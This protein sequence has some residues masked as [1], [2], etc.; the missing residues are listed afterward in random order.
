MYACIGACVYVCICIWVCLCICIHIHLYT[1]VC[2][3][4]YALVQAHFVYLYCSIS[5]IHARVSQVFLNTCMRGCVGIGSGVFSGLFVV[6]ACCWCGRLCFGRGRDRG[7]V[8][9]ISLFLRVLGWWVCVCLYTRVHTHNLLGYFK[10]AQVWDEHLESQKNSDRLKRGTH[11]DRI[12]VQNTFVYK[13]A[14]LQVLMIWANCFFS[15]NKS[16]FWEK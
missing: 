4:T 3:C 11:V 10:W 15:L 16:F 13:Y 2:G 9:Y 14:G 1:R 12:G 5:L 8:L 6:S 7:L